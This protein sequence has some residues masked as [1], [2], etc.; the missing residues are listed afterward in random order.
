MNLNRRLT[1]LVRDVRLPLAGTLVAGL[2]G[3][4]LIVLQAR[5]VARVVAR[6]FLAGDGWL[7]VRGS[8]G[9]LA[10]IILARGL[11]TWIGEIAARETAISIKQDLRL[12]LFR[13]LVQ[14]GPAHSGGQRTGELSAAAVE[15]VEALDAYFRQ[16]LPQLVLAALI[17]LTILLFVF[18][19][20][21]L[22]GLILLL[23][24]PLIPLFMI[25]IGKGAEAVTDRQFETLT[26]LS[27][28][29][30]DSLQ[31]LTTLKLFG[32]SKTQAKNLQAASEEFRDATMKV[33]RVT[34]LSSLALELVATL[35]TAIIA[36]EIGLRLLYYRIEFEGAFF[37]LLLAPE[38]Y[39]PLRSLG[40]RFHAGMSGAS[41]AR[42][43]FALL[44]RPIE[45]EDRAAPA[46]RQDFDFS[47]LSLSQV[48]FIYQE[49]EDPALRGINLTIEAGQHTALV[50]ASGAGKSTLVQLLMRFA[51]PTEGQIWVDDRLLRDI[52]SSA[53][54]RRI[55]WV[56]QDPFIFNASVAENI[57]LAQPDA[58]LD[59]VMAAARAADL[60]DWISHLP[61]GY[62]TT[63]GEA[64]SLLSSGQAQ[65]LA[66]ARAFLKDA[67]ILILDEPTSSQDP[68][69]EARLE[70]SIRRL[71]QGRTVITIAHRLNTVFRADRIVVLAAGR[72]VERGSHR[73]LMESGGYY[74]RMI[75]A[76]L[77]EPLHDGPARPNG[78]TPAD[79]RPLVAPAPER[80]S[81]QP[82]LR[83]GRR[84]L[85]FLAG[86]WRRVALSVCLGTATVVGG[87][88][89]VGTSGWLIS[90]AALHPPLADL[91]VAIV[92]VRFFGLSRGLF[93][94]LERLTAHDIT[95]RLL[96]RLR[97]WF[98]RAIEPLAP[99]GLSR[100][101]SGDLLSRLVADVNALEDFYVR[102]L[103]PTLIAILV[104]G[105]SATY[106]GRFDPRLGWS[107]LGFLLAAGA[108]MPLLIQAIARD[109][110]RKLVAQRAEL[111]SQLVEGI[112]GLADLLAFGRQ[113]DREQAIARSGDRY[114]AAERRLGWISG[115][116][117]GSAVLLV[118]FG[119]WSVLSLAVAGVGAGQVP[120]V[121]LAAL[122]M[123]A[124]AS[125]E[126][127]APLPGAGG[128]LGKIL[129]S[130]RRIFAVAD[131]APPEVAGGGLSLGTQ[132]PASIE[133]RQLSFRYPGRR[134]PALSDIN[135]RLPA[136]ETLAV[137]GPSGAGKSTLLWLL[138]RFWQS[139]E[140]EIL[141]DGRPVGQYG[142]EGVRAHFAVVPQ[143]PFLF[144]ATVRENLCLGRPGA[145]QAEVERAAVQA[146]IHDFVASL[147]A[148]YNT[149]IGEKG[150]RLSGGERQRLAIARSLVLRRPIMVFDEPT[151]NLDPHT[152]RELLD[153]IFASAA[154][155][156]EEG[157]VAS[158]ILITH[159]LVGLD[160]A[161]E[162]LVMDRGR[163]VERGCEAALLQAGG[164][165]RHLLSVQNRV[166]AA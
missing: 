140:G 46:E 135:F 163:I 68:A 56:P 83:L 12:R 81:I 142:L 34:F 77:G 6:V 145:S 118:N 94:Y 124:L 154:A 149:Y 125:F 72:V 138:M 63:V 61:E 4:I 64:G 130:A 104:T 1:R 23:T 147:P 62:E 31:G 49:G 146:Q 60:H 150:L 115:L 15:G 119:M 30:L 110:G 3:A 25:L 101:R 38:F 65:R 91:Q 166:L 127:V 102:F 160:R 151:A 116:Q 122:T 22:S 57:R 39:L 36:V 53:W 41:A 20:D 82:S 45:I 50:G 8:L 108:G 70:E 134:A 155:A 136:G 89:L 162:I 80:L 10:L 157:Q 133:F 58:T 144:N 117:E 128:S 75:Q 152:E 69:G 67:P 11:Q 18:P 164:L 158:T 76:Q 131:S 98:Y 17:P 47:S 113:S 51:D 26:R 96:A 123:V 2:V 132:A 66:L 40:A 7:A 9:V 55:G 88:G 48:G 74:A 42:T 95:F 78:R 114:A 35:S 85:G 73:E 161:D 43:I 165:Y 24:A 159:R 52:P 126:A 44:D 141:L 105:A 37:L 33:L 90:A 109:P 92:G 103:S 86:S 87:I 79:A 28:H 137:V 59:G 27:A 14:L 111:H 156:G 84:L 112:Q 19:L 93:R 120:G 153:V 148:G 13:H 143:Q 29:F 107:L 5:T 71:M 106:L 32:A 21:P 97:T 100:Y 121:M 139:Q 54:R 16:Y 99:A 129:E